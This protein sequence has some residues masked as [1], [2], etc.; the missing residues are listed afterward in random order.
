MSPHPS[1][2]DD[3]T[4]EVVRWLLEQA[5]EPEPDEHLEEEL[6]VSAALGTLSQEERPLVIAHLARCASCRETLAFMMRQNDA[7][8]AAPRRLLSRKLMFALAVAACVVVALGLW[9]FLPGGGPQDQLALARAALERGEPGKA[10]A[11][12]TELL[13]QPTLDANRREEASA[14]LREA[15]LS[16]GEQL[17]RER[18][19]EEALAVVEEM[20]SRRLSSLALDVIGFSASVKSTDSVVLETQ[21]ALA[22]VGVRVSEEG[23][24]LRTQAKSTDD[25]GKRTAGFIQ[26][27]YEQAAADRTVRLNYAYWLLQKN[28]A[29]RA[30]P[31]FDALVKADAGDRAA[32]VGLGLAAVMMEDGEQATLAFGKAHE[33]RPDE[34]SRANLEA[35]RR[36]RHR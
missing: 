14:T 20:G 23:E 10:Y 9:L 28:R 31:I 24:L 25:D 32:W 11:L 33:L 30:R 19:F 17:L 1:P 6:M 35:A 4:I 22:D 18:R 15:A 34:T 21:V 8:D 36:L 16:W 27:A 5:P 13:D 29:E 2:P 26:R 12:L 3:P 7:G